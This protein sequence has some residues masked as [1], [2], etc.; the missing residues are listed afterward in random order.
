MSD[1]LVDVEVVLHHE[2]DK[3]YRVSTTGDDADAKWVPKSQCE[4]EKT[5]HHSTYILTCSERTAID[6]EL[7]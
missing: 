7:V 6:K 1:K 3:A 4:L 2:T 5:K